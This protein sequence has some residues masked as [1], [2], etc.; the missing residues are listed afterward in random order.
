MARVALEIIGL[1][2]VRTLAV[3]VPAY[4][5]HSPMTDYTEGAELIDNILDVLR[6]QV[7]ECD[8]LQGVSLTYRDILPVSDQLQ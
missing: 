5:A 2:A 6:K 1:K 3:C 8:A 7:E 4:D